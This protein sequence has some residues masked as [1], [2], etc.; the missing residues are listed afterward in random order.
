MHSGESADD[1]T[2]RPGGGHRTQKVSG[3][4]LLGHDSAF[5]SPGVQKAIV[6]SQ[7]EGAVTSE[8]DPSR[9]ISAGCKGHKRYNGVRI[10]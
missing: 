10:K 1:M 9:E 5:W 7:Q 2:S 4:I 8:R 3:Q 6:I